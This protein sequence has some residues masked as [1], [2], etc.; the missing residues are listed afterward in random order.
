VKSFDPDEE[1]PYVEPDDGFGHDVAGDYSDAAGGVDVEAAL[2]LLDRITQDLPGGGEHRDGQRTMVARVAQAIS[3]QTPLAI[4]AGTGVGK[5]LA[6]LVPAALSGRRVVVATHTKNLQDQLARKD[7]PAVQDHTSGV[8]V[9]ILKGKQ[10]YLCR[11]RLH[12]VGRGQPTFDDGAALPR[13]VTSQVRSII[14]WS[15]TTSTGDMDELPFEVLPGARRA[16]TV[17]PQ[18]CVGRAKCEQG[19][20]CFHEWAKDRAGSANIVVV[21]HSLYASHLSAGKGLLP[22][23]DVVVLDEAHEAEDVFASLLGTSLTTNRLRG[24]ASSAR[25]LLGAAFETRCKELTES[26]DRVEA[27]LERQFDAG[28]RTGLGDEA[29]IFL[30]QAHEHVVALSEAVKEVPAADADAEAR[31]ART[32]G[33]AV[34]LANDVARVLKVRS[35]ELLH[36]SKIDRD[37]TIEVS[38]VEVGPVLRDELWGEVTGILTSATLPESVPARLGLD[39]VALVRVESPFDYANNSLLYVPDGIPDRKNPAAED[40]IIEELVALITAARGR[41]LALFTSRRMMQ[42]AHQEVSRRVKYEILVQGEQSRQTTIELFRD[43]PETSLF[44]TSSFWQ[45]IDVQG[46]SLSL[47]V[48]DRLPFNPPD[49]PLFVARSALVTNS[50]MELSVPNATMSLAQG[51]GR[52]IRSRTDR[53]VVAVMDNRLAETNYGRRMIKHLPPMP[54]TRE[55]KVV[56]DFLQAL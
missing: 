41:T 35:G 45:G 38:L 28:E 22:A 43:N 19:A 34:H 31:K 10:N 18:E 11:V 16:V 2:A 7:A 3:N 13:D 29:T 36:L 33:P 40:F 51:V 12:Q 47:V 55:R 49:D 32:S 48:I 27:A 53:G 14:E 30:R 5:S 50:F 25:S 15:D 6:Y 8:R 39:D 9:E 56:E 54:R 37:I 1:N 4:E 24:L 26:A 52:L 44:A 21:N 46:H 17:T 23:H 42:R 20:N